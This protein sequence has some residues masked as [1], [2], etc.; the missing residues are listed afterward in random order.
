MPHRRIPLLKTQPRIQQQPR[1]I[2]R[3]RGLLI[4]LAIPTV[5]GEAVLA[6]SRDRLI[7]AQ[8]GFVNQA[9]RDARGEGGRVRAVG[10]GAVAVRGDVEGVLEDEVEL[11][12]GEGGGGVAVVCVRRPGG[13]GEVEDEGGGEGGV[14]A[15]E[16]LC[17]FVLAEE[18][19][20]R[21]CQTTGELTGNRFK[22]S[23]MNVAAS[24]TTGK[25]TPRRW[26]AR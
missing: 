5:R 6:R 11:R 8:Q 17:V 16:G 26:A 15:E 19:E 9:A 25:G 10:H 23:L 3:L 7:R 14:A 24:G 13:V 20:T 4:R 12:V 21:V 2:R 1:I 22:S 18:V